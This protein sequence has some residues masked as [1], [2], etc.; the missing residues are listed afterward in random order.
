MLILL[1]QLCYVSM[2]LLS[3]FIHLS[4]SISQLSLLLQLLL[5]PPVFP[6]HLFGLIQAHDALCAVFSLLGH[7]LICKQEKRHAK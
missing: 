7:G 5:L 3:L 4:R 6:G 2:Y 1:L